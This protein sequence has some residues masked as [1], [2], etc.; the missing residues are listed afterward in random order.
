[1]TDTENL[2]TGVIPRIEACVGT[3]S[4]WHL[5]I[6]VFG[7]LG[8][9]RI[10]YLHYPPLGAIDQGKMIFVAHGFPKDRIKQ[11]I[12]D[13]VYLSDP[14]PAI[15]MNRSD[16]FY[17]SQI[18][19]L[20]TLTKEQDE[21]VQ[22]R[23]DRDTPDGIAIQAFGPNRRNGYFGLA[24]EKESSRPDIV[25]LREMQCI[26]QLLHLRYCKFIQQHQPEPAKLSVREQEIL[27]WVARGKSNSVI[28]EIMG[29]SVHTV[30]AYL[31][32]IFLKL[33]TTDRITAT[34]KGIGNGLIRGATPKKPTTL[35]VRSA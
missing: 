31:R 20:T 28:A 26:C 2:L 32:R 24:L 16:P 3:D 12:E 33:G 4:L 8:F 6:D 35:G 10:A 18:R 30:D 19:D 23:E 14:I 9:P 29:L 5:A 34:V 1:M 21:I 13:K 17:W 11:Y 27:E 15:G 22:G 7:S 25:E